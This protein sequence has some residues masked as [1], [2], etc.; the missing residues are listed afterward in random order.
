MKTATPIVILLALAAGCA[1]KAPAPE[2]QVQASLSK[3]VDCSTA[4]ADIETLTSEKARTSQEIENGA[5]S[6]IPIGAVAHIFGRSEK[7]SFEIGTGEY[8][9]KLDAKIAEIKKQC[10]MD[11]EPEY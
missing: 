11:K 4:Q 7:E 6:I 8:N 2:K 5:S 9:R 1:A 3:S 10:T